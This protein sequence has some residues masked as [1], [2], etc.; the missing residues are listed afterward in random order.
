MANWKRR[1]RKLRKISVATCPCCWRRDV[2]G[3]T[4][5]R[6]SVPKLKQ[7]KPLPLQV[8]LYERVMA[9]EKLTMRRY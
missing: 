6:Y 1:K 8:E 7:F 4:G 3:N 9:G 2:H 5:D